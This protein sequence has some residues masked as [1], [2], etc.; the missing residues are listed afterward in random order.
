MV[1]YSFQETKTLTT[2]LDFRMVIDTTLLGFS[3]LR[4][5]SSTAVM[6]PAGP[7]SARLA[8]ITRSSNRQGVHLC[9]SVQRLFQKALKAGTDLT[10]KDELFTFYFDNSVT[11]QSGYYQFTPSTLINIIPREYGISIIASDGVLIQ[12][13]L[14][15]SV[16][17]RPSPLSIKLLPPR[18]VRR[19]ASPPGDWRRHQHIWSAILSVYLSRRDAK[20][21][22][23]GLPRMDFRCRERGKSAQQ[24]R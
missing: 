21:A 17:K 9:L 13:H 5:T 10:N 22:G 19:T 2:S 24:L 16:A 3:L 7:I 18:R 6:A 14:A 15:R 11:P 4:L 1:S 12:K 20:S 8:P 23:P